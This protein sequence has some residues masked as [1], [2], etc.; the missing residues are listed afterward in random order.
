ML[1]T[2]KT[3]M[4]FLNIGSGALLNVIS[5]DLGVFNITLYLH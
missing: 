1:A 2:K 5:F 3:Q 4:D